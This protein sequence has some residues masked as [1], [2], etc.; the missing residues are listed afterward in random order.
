MGAAEDDCPE[1]W[2]QPGESHVVRGAAVLRTVLGS[3]VGVTFWNRRLGIGAMCHAMLPQSPGKHALSPAAA[4]RYVDLT[5]CDVAVQLD[6]LGAWR[7]ETEVKVFGGA[8]VLV[9]EESTRR[10]TVGRLNC[11]AALRILESEG[12]AVRASSLGGKCGMHID[13]YTATGEVL[14]RRLKATGA[15]KQRGE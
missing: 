14:L 6:A 12:F 4:R 3:C 1:I 8:D 5:I 11:E 9:V 15:E 7:S 2:V 13:F 10:A